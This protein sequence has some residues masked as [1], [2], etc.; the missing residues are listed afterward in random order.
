MS[1]NEDEGSVPRAPISQSPSKSPAGESEAVTA[2]PAPAG[3][4]C[5][6]MIR[7]L[8]TVGDEAAIEA[9]QGALRDKRISS[10]Q[11]QEILVARAVQSQ[12][13]HLAEPELIATIQQEIGEYLQD[14]PIWH[15]AIHNEP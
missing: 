2:H 1:G 4:P 11:A 12:L 10:A 8:S 9:I 6:E 14:D 7:E 3:D 5:A 13:S 15:A